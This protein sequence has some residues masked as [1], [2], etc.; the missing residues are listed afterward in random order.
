VYGR[1]PLQGGLLLKRTRD[2]VRIA[3][4]WFCQ[5]RASKLEYLKFEAGFAEEKKA[6][7]VLGVKDDIKNLFKAGLI[8]CRSHNEIGIV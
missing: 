6:D 3:R 8:L 7:V 2:E 5:N 1:D 4:R